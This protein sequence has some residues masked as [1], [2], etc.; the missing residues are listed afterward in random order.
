MTARVF[1]EMDSPD[2]VLV[3]TE[4]PPVITVE[5]GV[6]FF[7]VPIQVGGATDH[8]ELDGLEE[9]GAHPASAISF[10]SGSVADALAGLA[11]PAPITEPTTARTL[12]ADDNGR[13]ILCTHASG[14]EITVPGTL[15]PGHT[16]MLVADGGTITLSPGSGVTIT[17]PASAAEP[18]VSAEAGATIGVQVISSTRAHAFGALG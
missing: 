16:T 5:L 4:S 7:Q 8:A 3:D 1:I 13:T 18:R 11:H 14:C 9:A 17:G 2:A 15:T 10:G 6:P 12:T